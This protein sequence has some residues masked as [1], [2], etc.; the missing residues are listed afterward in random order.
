MNTRWQKRRW[1]G[2]IR[3]Q[4][5]VKVNQH[6]THVGREEPQLQSFHYRPALPVGFNNFSQ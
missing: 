4:R 6:Y 1:S 2:I 5:D 3:G